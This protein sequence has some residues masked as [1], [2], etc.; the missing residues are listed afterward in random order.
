MEEVRASEFWG[1]G[2]KKRTAPTSCLWSGTQLLSRGW[3]RLELWGELRAERLRAE[4]AG[5]LGLSPSE[6]SHRRHL[7]APSWG[8]LSGPQA[9]HPSGC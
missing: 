7:S 1:L 8:G 5:C 2:L 4:E 3:S 6:L 9:R